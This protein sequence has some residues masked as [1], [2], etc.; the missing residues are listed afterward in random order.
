MI[1]ADDIS[2]API[3]WLFIIKLKEKTH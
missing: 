2:F 1:R 3:Y